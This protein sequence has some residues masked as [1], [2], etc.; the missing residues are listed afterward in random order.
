MVLGVAANVSISKLFLAGI[1]PGL[2]MGWPLPW[3]G[4]GCRSARTSRRRPKHPPQRN[5]SAQGIHLALFLPVI[6][7]VGFKDG[8]FHPHRGS[9]RGGGVR[10][11]GGHP[12]V[13]RELHWR[14][15]TAVF[16][17]AAKTTAV[18][19]FLVAA[20]MVSAWLITV[21]DIPRQLIDILKPLI[22]SPMLLMIAIMLL[23]WWPK[24]SK[25]GRVPVMPSPVRCCNW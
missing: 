16:V 6:V 12:L 7:I 23:V 3:P 8:R 2:M 21:A 10:P 1:V 18:I 5:P 20:A 4:I 25:T 19:M 17:S 15:L 22:D 11:A 24:A 9:G 14:E 13:Y